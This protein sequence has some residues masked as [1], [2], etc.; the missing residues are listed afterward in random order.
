[1]PWWDDEEVTLHLVITHVIVDL[2]RHAGHADILREGI[3]GSAGLKDGVSNL[4]EGVDWPA[5]VERLRQ[6]AEQFP[7][8]TK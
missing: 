3:D 6:V 8:G 4:P 5:Y 7:E 1:V 2:A